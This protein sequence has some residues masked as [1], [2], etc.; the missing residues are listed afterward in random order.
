[1]QEEKTSLKEYRHLEH[2]KFIVCDPR[3][4]ALQVVQLMHRLRSDCSLGVI[5]PFAK[6]E[7]VIISSSE[8]N[9]TLRF[10]PII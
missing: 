1:M 2:Y 9:S 5:E 6:G 3:Q 10:I 8:R 7:L 4:H